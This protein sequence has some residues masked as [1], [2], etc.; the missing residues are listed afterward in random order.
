M[1]RLDLAI[2]TS[3]NHKEN[4]DLSGKQCEQPGTVYGA[5]LWKD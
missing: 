4:T 3:A 1:L 5:P 2:G